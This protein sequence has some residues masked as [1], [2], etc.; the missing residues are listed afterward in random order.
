MPI[1]EKEKTIG[2]IALELQ[3]KTPDTFDPTE[4]SDEMDKDYEENI[5]ICVE[6]G[7]KQYLGDF[8]VVVG[9]RREK[10]LQNIIR[11]Q[12][13]HRLTCPTPQ[14]DQTVYK[15]HK[16][17]DAIEF[18]WVVPSQQTCDE[19]MSNKNLIEPE[20]WELLK[21]VFAFEDG[22]LLRKCKEL[23]NEKDTGSYIFT[24]KEN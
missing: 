18:I 14:Y 3:D 24:I 23:N 2:Q 19:F 1:D 10:L 17:D 16:K 21:A 7:K 20:E 15:Y 12:I 22:T 8:Y 11:R 13:F 5:V 6:R 4:L 9:V